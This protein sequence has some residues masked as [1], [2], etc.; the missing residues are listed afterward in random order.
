MPRMK[1]AKTSK[2]SRRSSKVSVPRGPRVY[3][4]TR[5][6]SS[7]QGSANAFPLAIVTDSL[8]GR[9]A[10][11]TGLQSGQNLALAFRLDQVDLYLNGTV[12]STFAMPNYTE[13]TN[14]FDQYC[15]KKVDVMVLA[16]YCFAPMNNVTTQF[17]PW[18]I[19]AADYDNVTS[20]GATSLMQYNGAKYTQLLGQTN[21]VNSQVLRSIKPQAALS[22]ARVTGSVGQ[23][24]TDDL[25]IST[26]NPNIQHFGVKMA[27]DDSYN[28]YTVNQ[29]TAQLNFIIRYHMAFRDVV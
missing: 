16:T 6:S 15:I 20:T 12:A 21:S 22:V 1:K 28:G 4:F 2:K 25:W 9:P 26:D 27:L 17:L 18:I 29:T 19:H 5:L 23:S 11:S 13:F 10:F 8:T 3:S 14:L 7:N 24:P